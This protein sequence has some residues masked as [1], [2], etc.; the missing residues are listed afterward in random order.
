ML[1]VSK[2]Y[3][4]MRFGCIEIT[5][6]AKRRPL[7]SSRRY[8][9]PFPVGSNPEIRVDLVIRDDLRVERQCP[10]V[11]ASRYP[12]LPPLY[13]TIRTHVTLKDMAHQQ[14]VV[15]RLCR[16]LGDRFVGHLDI[17]EMFR[18]SGLIRR[19]GSNDREVQVN[20][21]QQGYNGTACGR[22]DLFVPSQP[23][24]RNVTELR[25]ISLHLVLV[26]SMRDSSEVEDSFF[27]A[28]CARG[29]GGSG[30]ER[31]GVEG[32]SWV[33]I[34]DEIEEEEEVM[35]QPPDCEIPPTSTPTPTT[36][37]DKPRLTLRFLALPNFS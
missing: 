19:R 37:T 1:S 32:R 5:Y 21:S 17:S 33:V 16:D 27:F 28:L 8:S 31:R 23:Q 15:H 11:S 26:K 36:T 2:G 20:L 13:A 22:T 3:S 25:E 30:E 6:L 14:V 12:I 34:F 10:P 4:E 18:C 9:S 7:Q 35:Y 24:P 29:S